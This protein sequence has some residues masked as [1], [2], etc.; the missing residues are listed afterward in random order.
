MTDGFIGAQA[1]RSQRAYVRT[2][3]FDYNFVVPKH[4]M[5]KLTGEKHKYLANEAANIL[6]GS[7]LNSEFRLTSAAC[8]IRVDNMVGS[9]ARTRMLNDLVIDCT[10]RCICGVLGD[11][12]ALSSFAPT[13]GCPSPPKTRISSFHYVVLPAHLNGNHWGVIIVRLVYQLETPS[14][15]PYYYEPLRGTEFL[16][17]MEVIFQDTMAKFLRNWHH[18]TMQATDF[19]VVENGVWLNAP[20][21]PDGSS[22]GVLCIAQTYAVLNDSTAFANATV[23]QDDVAIMRLRIMWIILMQP[24]RSGNFDNNVRAYLLEPAIQYLLQAPTGEEDSQQETRDM[25]TKVSVKW[26]KQVFQDVVV[27][28]SAPVAVLKAQLYTLTSV[29]VERQKLMSKAWK[30]M[31]KDD[32][33]LATLDKLVDGTGIMLMGSAEVV[34]KPKEPIIFIEDMTTKDIAA[35]GTVY[36]AGLVNLGNTCYMNATLQCLRP[37]KELREALKAQPGGVSA[38]LTNNF[39]SALKDMYGQLDGSLDS[40]TPSMFVSV[41]RRAYPQF[42]QQAPRSGGYMQQDSEEFLST[43]FST[44]Q[45]TLTQPA[46]GLKTLGPVN[47]VVDALFGLEMDEKLECT[48]TDMEPAVVKKEKALK[49]VCNITIETNHLSEGIKIGL[50]GTIEKHSEV[51]GGNAVWKKTMRINR[52]PKYLCVQFMRFYWKATPE[53]RD[54]AGVKCKMLRPISFP[55]TLDV[56]DFCSDE[57]KATMKISRDRNAEKILNEF[58]DKSAGE[59]KEDEAEEKKEADEDDA[60]DGLSEED[61][62]A[63]ETARAL[64]MGAKSP[65]IDLPIDFQGNYELF[66]ILTHKGRSADSGHYMAWVRHEGDDWYC[67]DDDDVSPCKTEDIMKLKG[68][69]DWHM[70][71]LAFYRA[72][73]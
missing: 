47:N 26:G 14:I 66:A 51:K 5:T 27:D 34:Q 10:I 3:Q 44:L 30:G 7:C 23:T 36:P 57:L 49:L 53:S 17:T 70:A 42:A 46:G 25:T 63:L 37:V 12:Y 24:E 31:L 41:L 6:R 38:D 71:Y 8:S 19:P 61:K 52:L 16:A 28:K 20:T 64:S 22:C 62:A 15:T 43:L 48:E 1:V 40:I 32:V 72:K 67:Y 29:P 73:N 58:K 35:T 50:E 68:G 65:G 69:G 13:M 56:Y 33:D 54:H 9:L 2:E 18:E 45:Q 21:Q 60:M 55:L 4:L 39:T 59:K 11:C